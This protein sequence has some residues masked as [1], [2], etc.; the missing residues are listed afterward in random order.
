MDTLEHT[1][2]ETNREYVDRIRD[3]IGLPRFT[4]EQLTFFFPEM[5]PEAI[6]PKFQFKK[7]YF[8]R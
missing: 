3:A 5:I 6:Y 8:S 4:D 2:F 1:D 7:E